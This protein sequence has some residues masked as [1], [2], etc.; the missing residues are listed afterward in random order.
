ML[1][2]WENVVGLNLKK[3][4]YEYFPQ[5]ELKILELYRYKNKG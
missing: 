5:K 1:I 2:S 4:E 3:D